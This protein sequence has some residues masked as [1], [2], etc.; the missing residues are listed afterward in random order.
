[1]PSLKHI[2]Y[3]I[4]MDQGVLVFWLPEEELRWPGAQV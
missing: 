1:M 2:G 4:E 3:C